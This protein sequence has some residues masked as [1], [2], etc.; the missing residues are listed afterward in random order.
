M[1]ELPGT[2][3]DPLGLCAPLAV[4]PGISLVVGFIGDSRACIC[5]QFVYKV[6]G[7]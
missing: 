4:L 6:A 7:L 5:F 1:T 2:L 3:H